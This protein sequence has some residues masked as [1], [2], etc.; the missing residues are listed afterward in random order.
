[1]GMETLAAGRSAGSSWLLIPLLAALC[2]LSLA[3]SPDD[4]AADLPPAATDM[5][6]GD[7]SG[8]PAPPPSLLS[9]F[10]TQSSAYM[11]IWR[12]ALQALLARDRDA[13]EGAFGQLLERDISAFRVALLAA[14]AAAAA[15]CCSWSRMQS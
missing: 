3:Q 7:R 15:V 5:E 6:S 11:M 9:D 2:P 13:A 12:D 8:R 14:E 4:G 10:S 1:M